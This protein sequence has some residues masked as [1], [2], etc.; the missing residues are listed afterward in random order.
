MALNQAPYCLL[1]TSVGFVILSDSHRFLADTTQ[2]DAFFAL[3]RQMASQDFSQRSSKFSIQYLFLDCTMSCLLYTSCEYMFDKD[4]VK[5]I[6][7]CR[8]IRNAIATFSKLYQRSKQEKLT[9]REE[10]LLSVFLELYEEDDMADSNAGLSKVL[11]D[12]D[13]PDAEAAVAK[14]EPGEKIFTDDY[15][16]LA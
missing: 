8:N 11:Y 5:V 12:T 14:D 15:D 13:D 6:Y 3:W 9:Y 10:H 16:D 7:A 4:E 2:A 1:Y